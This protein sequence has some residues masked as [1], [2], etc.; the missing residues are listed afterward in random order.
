MIKDNI[1][2]A[3]NYKDLSERIKVGLKFISETDL[4]ALENGRYEILGDEVYAVVQ[5]YSAKPLLE[6]KFEAHEKYTDIQ[7][8]VKG[9]E[10]IGVGNV[11]DF[12]PA[13]NYNA[14]KDIVFLKP[15]ENENFSLIE[16]KEN[17][18]AIFT[19][20]DAHMPSIEV[21]NR[22]YVKKTVVKVLK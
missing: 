5:D 3:E 16:I 2:N 22:N 18:F 13:T 11:K 4:S 20:D 10:K 14:E 15:K 7:F 9:Q 12:L 8:I 1:K 19:P 6:G 17:E 21:T